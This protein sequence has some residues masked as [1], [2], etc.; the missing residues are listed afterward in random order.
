MTDV[1]YKVPYSIIVEGEIVVNA[2]NK[3]QASI[4]ARRWMS[5]QNTKEL[6]RTLMQYGIGRISV[7]SQHIMEVE[8][9]VVR[10]IDARGPDFGLYKRREQEENERQSL[11]ASGGGSQGDEGP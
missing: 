8:E 2:R 1:K 5:K 4:L 3:G 10:E 7:Q 9:E 11:P 6:H